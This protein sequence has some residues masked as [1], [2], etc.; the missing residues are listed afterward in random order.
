MVGKQDERH[1]DDIIPSTLTEIAL[2]L[3]F[4]FMLVAEHFASEAAAAQSRADELAN[5][6]RSATLPSCFFIDSARTRIGLFLIVKSVGA[7]LYDV[8]I[9]STYLAAMS[10]PTRGLAPLPPSAAKYRHTT[11]VN[12]TTLNSDFPTSFT[13]P[14]PQTDPRACKYY[15]GI[16]DI[17]NPPN[18]GNKF[19]WQKYS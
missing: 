6:F 14:W 15:V 19:I 4:G 12:A 18:T 8:R 3:L 17:A 11:R 13:D 5:T 2:L 7:G 16:D 9:N 10:D 1:K